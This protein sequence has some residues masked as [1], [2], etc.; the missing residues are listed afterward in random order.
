MHYKERK[1]ERHGIFFGCRQKAETTTTKATKL[2]KQNT[3]LSIDSWPKKPNFT[4][5][6]SKQNTI[7]SIDSW[8]EKKNKFYYKIKQAKYYTI[9]NRFMTKKTYFYYKIKQAKYYTI[10]WF[11]TKN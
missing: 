11:M 8:P 7:L 2:S 6:L 4:T 9:H 3:K 1:K 5:K 10:H